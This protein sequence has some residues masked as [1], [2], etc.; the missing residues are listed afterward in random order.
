MD[1]A[2]REQIDPCLTRDGSTSRDDWRE[3]TVLPE[4]E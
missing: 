1:H 3:D 4:G 2:R